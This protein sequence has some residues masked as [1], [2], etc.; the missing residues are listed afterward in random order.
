VITHSAD[1]LPV[2]LNLR[3]PADL[4]DDLRNWLSESYAFVD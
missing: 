3:E 4:T 2:D 1:T